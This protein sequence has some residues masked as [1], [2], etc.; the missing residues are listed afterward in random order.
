MIK[1]NSN[2]YVKMYLHAC[3]YPSSCIGGYLIGSNDNDISDILPV[4]H[5]A[6]IGPILDIAAGIADNI[7]TG[8]KVIGYYC[9]NNITTIDKRQV[10]PYYVQKV[11]DS[12]SSN[13]NN[14]V[15]LININGNKMSNNE[16]F[17]EA[18]DKN[19]IEMKINITTGN[20]IYYLFYIKSN[21]NHN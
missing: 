4:C 8:K 15:I 20:N 18:K 10:N 6:P 9:S 21:N 12:I 11:I 7:E 19:G 16:N 2:A 13:N 3:K 14:H 17:I 5:N 1:I